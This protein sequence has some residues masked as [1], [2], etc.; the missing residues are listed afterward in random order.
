M[1][2]LGAGVAS[3]DDQAAAA[4]DALPRFRAETGG[5]GTGLPRRG[6]RLARERPT[7]ATT[8]RACN[9][10]P[11]PG[12]APTDADPLA[13]VNLLAMPIC[14][15]PRSS[16]DPQLSA[17]A[18]TP[19]D[20][21]AG[22][23][24][25]VFGLTAPRPSERWMGNFLEY[26]LRAPAGPFEP[27]LVVDRDGEPAI[28]ANGLPGA[29]TQSLWSDGPD[30]NLLDGGAAGRMP[31]AEARN[32]Y[33]DIAGNRLTDPAN[34]LEPGNAGIGR[35]SLG[36]GPLDPVSVDELLESFRALRTLGD[37]GLRA[38]AIVEYPQAGLRI[39][40]AATQDGVLHAFDADS[41][42][43][44]WAW[45]PKELLGRMAAL[46]RDA[47]T[48]VRSHGIDG[49]LVV[50]RHDPDGD[51][52]I[53]PAA[54]EHLWLLFGLGRGGARYYA[55]DVALPRDPRLLWS[56]ELPDARALAL[57]EPVVARLEIA[58]SGQD[59][60]GWVVMLAGGYD[61]RFDARGATGAGRGSA[62]LAVEATTGRMLWSAGSGEADLPIAGLSSVAAAPRLLDL[63]GDGRIDRA[64]VLDVVGN[65]WRIDFEG[66]RD[67]GTLASAHRLA[68]LDAVG[69]RFH[70]HAG[71]VGRATPACAAGSRL[72]WVP[73]R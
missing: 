32:L 13:F 47:P 53:D 51:G 9:P 26:A 45:M 36:L 44:L 42:V 55:L 49:P 22:A 63:D 5:C 25:V 65:L 20:T 66:G 14:A 40:Y 31:L 71:H 72:R 6:Q 10:P 21:R 41:G 58:N 70:F 43:E 67:A 11:W 60:D 27:P 15:T 57:A 1:A 56:V 38:P 37:P 61:R 39:A 4:A 29:G 69:R 23:T 34:R 16:R 19:F 30:A 17:A 68:R 50:H 8:C 59:A 33:T 7:C 35:E 46:V 62:V 24:G 52:R 12:S 54:G 73:V 48:T 28:D 18:L 64:Y 3:G 2:Y